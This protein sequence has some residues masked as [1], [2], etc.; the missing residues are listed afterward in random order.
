MQNKWIKKNSSN[1]L[2]L[3]FLGWACDENMVKGLNFGNRDIL[4]FFDYSCDLSDVKINNFSE[5]ERIELVAWSFGVWVS[6]FLYSKG[7]LPHI[8]SALALNGTPKPIDNNYGIHEL[9]FRL[10]VK[11]LQRVGLSKFYERI[12]SDM[13]IN[14]C[15]RAITQQIEELKNL[16]ILSKQQYTPSLN[17]NHALISSRD[18]IFPPESM[19]NYWS[20]SSVDYTI[21]QNTEHYPFSVE[22]MSIINDFLSNAR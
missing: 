15:Q 22:G 7:V 18:V 5:Y 3:L 12:S 10:T 16:E 8:N 11:G 20:E 14:E 1:T 9:N 21:A 13:P 2:M 4:C 6:D 19:L 17:W